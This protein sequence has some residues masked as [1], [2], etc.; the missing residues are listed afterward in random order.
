MCDKTE[1]RAAV[2][3]PWSGL[4]PRPEPPGRAGPLARPRGAAKCPVLPPG[5]A[6]G[7]GLRRYQAGARPRPMWRKGRV[8]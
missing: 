5:P 8:E 7:W 3:A 2:A 6:G 4:S 1:S